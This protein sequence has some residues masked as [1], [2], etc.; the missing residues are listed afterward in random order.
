MGVMTE[1]FE[2]Q[3]T[4]INATWKPITDGKNPLGLKVGALADISPKGNLQMS[5]LC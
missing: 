5:L 1:H 2:N 4:T 3:S